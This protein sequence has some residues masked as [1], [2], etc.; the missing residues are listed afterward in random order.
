MTR[1]ELEVAGPIDAAIRDTVVG[2][3]TVSVLRRKVLMITPYIRLAGIIEDNW[4]HGKMRV[5]VTL[6]QA[7]WIE[8]RGWWFWSRV[9]AVYQTISGDNP[10]AESGI[11]NA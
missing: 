1:H 5:A 6:H 3:D 4:P 2:R 11:P 9:K 7:V 8:Y 10:Y